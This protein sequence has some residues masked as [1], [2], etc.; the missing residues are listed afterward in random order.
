MLHPMVSIAVRSYGSYNTLLTQRLL[1]S[2]KPG[3]ETSIDKKK[4]MIIPQKLL[5]THFVQKN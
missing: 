1:S 4:K 3:Q 5:H 2:D